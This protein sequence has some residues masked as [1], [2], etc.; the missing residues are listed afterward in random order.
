M[1]GK[2][3]RRKRLLPGIGVLGA[4]GIFC[5][6]TSM[7]SAQKAGDTVYVKRD[8]TE[9]KDEGG[10]TTVATVDSSQPLSVIAIDGTKIQVKT[11]D[12]KTGY[13]S[14]LRITTKAPAGGSA[15][16][17]KDD[18]G[19]SERSNVSSVRGLNPMAESYVENGEAT[20]KAKQDTET[21]AAL[22]K[23][24]TADDVKN[25]AKEGGVVQK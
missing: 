22:A 21:I 5:L 9:I 18:L 7:A 13:L 11:A 19:P 2:E 6:T 1:S 17:I 23:A 25:F 14:K 15:L 12:G 20:E 16:S 4:A 3:K 8:G 10:K 24:I